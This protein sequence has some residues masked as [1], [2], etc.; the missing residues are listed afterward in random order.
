MFKENCTFKALGLSDQIIES[1]T[2]KGFQEPSEV[3]QKTIP[4]LLKKPQSMIVQAQTGSGKTASFGL[5][6]LDQLEENCRNTEALILSPTREL[7]QQ[8]CHE[9]NSFKGTKEIAITPIVGGLSMTNQLQKLKQEKQVIIGTPGRVI[10]HLKRGSINLKSL[11]FLV[12]DEADEMLSMGFI[13]DID[14]ILSQAPENVKICC[15]SATIP[16]AIRKLAEEY[17]P[18]CLTITTKT[19]EKSVDTIQQVFYE[20][21]Q[22][23]RMEAL[24][25]VIDAEDDMHGI[26]FCQRKIDADEVVAELMKRNYPAAA[27][28]GDLSQYQRNKVTNSFRN[29]ITKLLVA[30]DIAARGLDIQDLS[31]VINFSLPQELENYIHRIG[32]TGRAGKQGTAIS[33]IAPNEFY[34]LNHIQKKLKISIEK[35]KLPS[36]DHLIKLKKARILTKIKNLQE[37]ELDPSFK[38]LADDLLQ[39]SDAQTSVAQVLQILYE[40]LFSN[41]HY[42]DIEA[43]AK[44]GKR[45][46]PRKNGFKGDR[47]KVAFHKN[48][49]RPYSENRSFRQNKES[50]TEKKKRFKFF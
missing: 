9:L 2:K 15:F 16:H 48:K 32:R 14:Y 47:G 41:Q 1:I 7:S 43:F 20:V 8:V 40:Q 30:T 34:K 24:F 42:R 11:K 3:Q 31:H 29:R 46:G 5:P 45:N 37:K 26:I 23:D 25:R 39:Q 17:M 13:E 4:A 10:D 28:H 21:H 19:A 35:K 36:P 22:R 38:T 49:K 18:D 12:L 33:I 44:G 50:N 27:L 6:I